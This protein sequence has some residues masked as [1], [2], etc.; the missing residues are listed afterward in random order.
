MNYQAVK[1]MADIFGAEARRYSVLESL[2]RVLG[3][4]YGYEE[5]RT[6]LVEPT[7]LFVRSIGE[8]TDIVEKEMFS[9]P[10]PREKSLSLRPEGTA[11]V[12]RAYLQHSVYAQRGL[13]RYYYM[14][15][16]F[17]RE[18]PQAGR[19]RQFHQ[20]GVE[21]LGSRHP[22]IDT[23]IIDLLISYLEAAGMTKWE[24]GINSVGCSSC[25]P[26]YRDKLI[27]YLTEHQENL[28]DLCISRTKSNPLRVLDCKN[29]DCREIVAQ[30]PKPVE[31][32]C[33]KCE[34]HF[35]EVRD[36]LGAIAVPYLVKPN[37][38]RGLDYYTSVVFEV[39]GLAL[40]AQDAVAGGGRYDTLIEELGGPDLGASG[41]SIGLERLLIGLEGREI[42]DPVPPRGSIYLVTVAPDAFRPNFILLSTLRR[43]GFVA[44][45]DYQGRSVKAQM[46][47]ANKRDVDYVLIRGEEEMAKG[48]VKLKD[49]KTGEERFVG[50]DE[51]CEKLKD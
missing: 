27:D 21:A 2:A 25:R 28:C 4:R 20:F 18:R 50:E 16:M 32:L 35:Q 42:P 1:G 7:E 47:E 9:F 37:L 13:A 23:E 36:L 45:M 34:T 15:P 49:M 29:P 30:S 17:R 22:A 8:T 14:G 38:V 26:G 6:P 5:I 39:S 51:V 46:R 11:G 3:S 40:G 24:L 43:N 33:G 31:Y 44:V 41:F 12:V 19:R 10:G 48:G